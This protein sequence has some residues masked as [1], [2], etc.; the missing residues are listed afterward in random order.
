MPQDLHDDTSAIGPALEPQGSISM[1]NPYASG[2]ASAPQS[3]YTSE[4]LLIRDLTMPP[5]PNFN[6]PQSP[7]SSPSA[8]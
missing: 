4:R 5:M 8:I 7:P 3:P 6:I 1:A 2:T